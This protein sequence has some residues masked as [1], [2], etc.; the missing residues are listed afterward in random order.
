GYVAIMGIEDLLDFNPYYH[1]VN[2]RLNFLDLA[3]FTEFVKAGVGTFAHM[4]LGSRPP[5]ERHDYYLPLV[6]RQ[7]G[8]P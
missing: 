2:D 3:Y 4:G 8:A 1:T 7:A 5:R 6:A